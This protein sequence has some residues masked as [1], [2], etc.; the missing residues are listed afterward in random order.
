MVSVLQCG[1]VVSLQEVS[2]PLH[3]VPQEEKLVR[4]VGGGRLPSMAEHELR[5]GTVDV[6]EREE[7]PPE[8]ARHPLTGRGHL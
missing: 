2:V 3:D 4:E 5:E 8:I 1:V 7:E 6:E